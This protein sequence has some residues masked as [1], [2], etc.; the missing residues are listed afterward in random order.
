MTVTLAGDLSLATIFRD[1]VERHVGVAAENRVPDRSPTLADVQAAYPTGPT[2]A[3]ALGYGTY[4]EVKG[5]RGDGPGSPYRRRQTLLDVYSRWRR[6]GRRPTGGPWHAA[7]RV[8]IEKWVQEATPMSA[9]AVLELMREQGATLTYFHAVFEYESDREREIG[10][11]V[12]V[13]PQ[14]LAEHGFSALV[15]AIPPIDWPGLA[16]AFVTA[17][18]AAYGLDDQLVHELEDEG[19]DVFAISF[20]I[21]RNERVDYDYRE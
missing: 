8:T 18:A 15:E 4:A 9:V 1:E 6:G 14:V 19:F 16:G 5:T 2:L 11:A 7:Q 10:A 3:E 17:W 20:D 21:G 12:Y 13:W